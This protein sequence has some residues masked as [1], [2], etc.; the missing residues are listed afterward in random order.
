[1]Y[2]INLPDENSDS[3]C[4]LPNGSQVIIKIRNCLNSPR[5]TIQLADLNGNDITNVRPLIY[6]KSLFYPFPE[7]KRAYGVFSVN[8][9]HQLLWRP[10]RPRGMT[11]AVASVRKDSP[12]RQ[13]PTPLKSILCFSSPLAAG[14]SALNAIF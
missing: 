10:K 14:F 1:M 3:L 13:M 4:T 5:K 12:I 8:E 9:D 6:N 11:A 7:I 2:I